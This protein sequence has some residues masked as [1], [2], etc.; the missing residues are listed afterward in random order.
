MADE[1]PHFS[2][3]IIQEY[4]WYFLYDMDNDEENK[5]LAV[6]DLE[7]VNV[8]DK[9]TVAEADKSTEVNKQRIINLSNATIDKII[10]Q[11]N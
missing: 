1:F 7:T 4:E 6:V 3:G 11:T 2:S 10:T 8:T 5:F 9:I